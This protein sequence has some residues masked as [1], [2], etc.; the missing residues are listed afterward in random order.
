MKAKVQPRFQPISAPIER[1]IAAAERIAT[2]STTPASSP[3][4][5]PIFLQAHPDAGCV[6]LSPDGNHFLDMCND[7]HRT[8]LRGQVPD[9]SYARVDNGPRPPDLPQ[10]TLLEER[11][12]SLIRVV[13]YIAFCRPVT[14][15]I[16]D[17]QAH[18]MYRMHIIGFKAPTPVRLARAFPCHP[19]ELPELITVILVGA[20]QTFQ[21]V[22]CLADRTPALF[23]RARVIAQWARHLA[24]VYRDLPECKLDEEA[25]REWERRPDYAIPPELLTSALHT[26]TEGEADALLRLIRN[27]QEGYAHTRYG[28]PEQAAAAA[29]THPPPASTGAIASASPPTPPPLLV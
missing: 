6:R 7:C 8:L 24:H 23:V 25:L 26:H 29:A 15:H 16:A 3:A 4:R 20:I 9:Y 14:A 28:T 18:Q 21:D 22:Q 12:V 13:R 27:D 1:A 11:I 17:D 19:S 5:I 10:L 2:G